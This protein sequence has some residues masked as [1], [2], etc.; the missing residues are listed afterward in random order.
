MFGPVALVMKTLTSCSGSVRTSNIPSEWLDK[1]T[2]GT[3]DEK[4]TGSIFLSSLISLPLSS[5]FYKIIR[6][7]ME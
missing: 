7:F 3:K 4:E 1:S 2:P 5:D 6:L